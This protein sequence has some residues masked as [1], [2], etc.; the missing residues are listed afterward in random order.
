M[1]IKTKKKILVTGAS[2]GIGRAVAL[3]AAK[4]GY[5]VIAHY[6]AS[7]E[8]AQS[9]KAE[10]DDLCGS[11][12]CSLIRFDTTNREECRK[13]LEQMLEDEGAPWG[14]VHNAGICKDGTF[15]SLSENDWDTVLTTNLDSFFNV[16]QPLTLPLARKK[17]GRI[18][19]MT[20]VS[21]IIG[22]RGQVNYSA[23]KAGIIGAAK[24]L[25]VELAS[26]HITVNCIAPGLI[27]T[28]MTHDVDTAQV[29]PAIPMGRAG[30]ADEVAALAVF[31]L[32]EGASYITRQVIA[33]SGGLA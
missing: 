24:A 23:S 8:A 18:I 10:I 6:N 9:L 25:A 31:L 28:D 20:S 5:F 16:L 2:R 3:A 12:S 1:D 33:V 7:E 26:R 17:C 19:A 22:N 4:E 27:E 13:K 32:S 15:A 30:R 21:G 11:A 29:L 14:I